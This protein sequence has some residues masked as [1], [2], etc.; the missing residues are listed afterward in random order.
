[1]NFNLLVNWELNNRN[2]SFML[3]AQFEVQIYKLA[4]QIK[5]LMNQRNVLFKIAG[6]QMSS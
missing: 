1:M 3:Y 2:S 4:L 6:S 5:Y